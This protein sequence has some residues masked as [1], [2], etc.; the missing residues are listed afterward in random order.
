M[1]KKLNRKKALV[2]SSGILDGAFQAGAIKRIFEAGFRPD[3]IAGNGIGALHT[4]FITSELGRTNNKISLNTI[5]KNLELFWK[6]KICSSRDLL[7]RKS[8]IRLALDILRK[9]FV[10]L[11]DTSEL[12][13][14]VLSIIDVENIHKSAIEAV[15]GAINVFSGETEYFNLRSPYLIEAIFAS[16]SLPFMM[17]Y[18]FIE[19]IPYIDAA[20]RHII[21]VRYLLENY[22]ISEMIIVLSHPTK[23]SYKEFNP[24]N[25]N[26][27]IYRTKYI[28]D[29]ELL[30]RD[31]RFLQEKSK[32]LKFSYQIIEPEKEANIDITK[33]SKKQIEE[34]ID[35]GYCKASETLEYSK[36]NI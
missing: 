31:L 4:I 26:Q 20:E 22:D 29:N 34:I 8:F 28:T 33:F 25:L 32:K 16:Y 35:E 24:G 2:L 1:G 12:E 13:E 9:K 30:H 21:P 17:P 10:S 14:H 36:L 6:I 5:A 19:N 27:L 7:K 23:L 11:Y 3:I 18:V 15:I